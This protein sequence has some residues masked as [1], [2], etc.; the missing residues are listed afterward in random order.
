MNSHDNQNMSGY[1]QTKQV[2]RSQLN[3]KISESLHDELKIF[4]VR[5]KKNINEIAEMALTAYLQD[6]GAILPGKTQIADSLYKRYMEK[7][8][9]S[10]E[11][12]A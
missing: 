3:V 12:T 10:R 6:V 8:E 5:A 11:E 1:I 9:K 7:K 2:K 4:S